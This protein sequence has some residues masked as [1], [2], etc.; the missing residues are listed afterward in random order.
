MND[1]VVGDKVVCVREMCAKKLCAKELRLTKLCDKVAC[2]REQRE[3]RK[4]VRDK[5]AYDKVVFERDGLTC[6][7]DVTKRHACHAKRRSMPQSA[8]PA[9]PSAGGCRQVPRHAK[10]RSV[11]GDYS[12]QACHE[13]QPS[14]TSATPATQNQGGCEQVPCP[15][16]KVPRRHGRLTAPKR[17]ARS[18]PVC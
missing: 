15:P 3:I 2:E 12:A 14:A 18:N 17:A 9:T 11:T 1:K 8:T 4:I 10:C 7:V 6:S 16:R 13:S 5:V